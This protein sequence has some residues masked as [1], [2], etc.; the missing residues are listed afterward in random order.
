[1]E[2]GTKYLYLKADITKGAAWQPKTDVVLCLNGH[3]FTQTDNAAAIYVPYTRSFTLCDC[4][5]KGTVTSKGAGNIVHLEGGATH[6]YT[7]FTMYGGNLVGNSQSKNAAVVYVS[8][9]NS[10]GQTIFNLYGGTISGN[11]SY[12]DGA[13]VRNA[14]GTFNMYGGTITG[15]TVNITGSSNTRARGAGV[16]NSGTFTMTGGTITG[17]TASGSGN[18]GGGVYN[19]GATMKISGKVNITGNTG[20]NVYLAKS[21]SSYTPPITI[22]GALDKS[23]KIGV[24][25]EATPGSSYLTVATGAENG[26]YDNITSDSGYYATRYNSDVLLSSDPLHIHAD[27]D[28]MEH[29]WTEFNAGSVQANGYYYLNT[30]SSLKTISLSGTWAPNGTKGI[31][32]CL[33]GCTLGNRENQWTISLVNGAELSIDDCQG[34]GKIARGYNNSGTGS[35]GGGIMISGGSTLTLNGGTITGNNYYNGAGVWIAKGTFIMNG[36]E[37][38][39]NNATEGGG[40]Y[41]AQG[42]KFEMNGGKITDNTGGG[43][44]LAA[45]TSV[46]TV[47][48]KVTITGN[49]GGNVYLK[50]GSTITIGSV[51]NDNSRIGV[52]VEGDPPKTVATGANSASTPYTGIFFADQEDQGYKV[53]QNSTTLMLGKHT[54]DWKF[55]VNEAGDTVTATCGNA[56]GEVPCSVNGGNG[57]SITIVKPAHA[58]YNDGLSANATW[59]GSFDSAVSVTVSENDIVY[60]KGTEELEGAPTDAGTYTAKLTVGDKEIKVTYTIAR[61][62]LNAGKFVLA[63]DGDLTYNGTAKFVDV[64]GPNGVKFTWKC[65]DKNGSEV[66]PINAGDYT[67]KVTV[68]GNANY[69]DDTLTSDKWT[70]TILRAEQKNAELTMANWNFG[71]TASDPSVTGAQENPT[72]TYDYKAKGAADS[73]YTG[74]KPSAAGDY[75]VR[76]TIAE[77]GNYLEKVLTADFT[78]N[79]TPATLIGAPTPNDRTYNG[80]NQAL[81]IDKNVTVEHGEMMYSLNGTNYSYGVP[82]RTDAGTYTVWYMVKG[83]DGYG[84]TEPAFVTVTI[85]KATITVTPAAGQNKVYGQNDPTLNFTASAGQNGETASFNG[86]LGRDTGENVGSYAITQGTLALKDNGSFKASNYELVVETDSTFEITKKTLT[87]LDLSGLTVTKVY[88][89]GTGAGTLTGTIGFVGKV[90]NDDVS[91]LVETVGEYDDANVG[92][93]KTITLTLKLD[94]AQKYCYTLESGTIQFASAEITQRNVE[95]TGAAVANKTYDGNT[96]APVTSVTIPGLNGNLVMGTDFEI[97]S[98]TFSDKNAGDNKT[99]TIQVELI[100]GAATNYSLTS[101]TYMTTAKIEQRKVHIT[102]ITANSREYDGT[103]EANS[104]LTVGYTLHDKVDGDDVGVDITAVFADANVIE[105]NY[106][107]L[108]YTLTGADKD[109]YVVD[110]T[111]SNQTATAMIEQKELTITDVTIAPKTYDGTNTASITGVTFDGLVNGETLTVETDYTVV[112]AFAFNYVNVPGSNTVQATVTLKNSDT[113]KN[114]TF[115]N[116][117]FPTVKK[118]FFKSAAIGPANQPITAGSV[119]SVYGETD[120]KVVVSGVKE[121][122]VLTFASDNNNIIVDENG[123]LTFLKSGTATITVTAAATANYNATTIMVKVNV[124][125][126]DI[127]ISALDRTAYVGSAPDL[128]APTPGTDYEIDGLVDGDDLDNLT[129]AMHYEAENEDGSRT[130]IL[131]VDMT[132]GTYIIVIELVSGTDD[133]YAIMPCEAGTLTLDAIPAYT[134]KVNDTEH[135]TAASNRRS[136]ARGQ[137]VTITVTPDEGYVLAGLTVT[138]RSGKTIAVTDKGDGKYTFKMPGSRVTVSASFRRLSVFTDIDDAWY[139]D[140]ILWAEEMNIALDE[141]GSG[142]F[143]P[144]EDCTRA[145]IVTFLWRAA[146]CPEPAGTENPFTDVSESDPWY[147]AVL[148]AWET[149]VTKGYGVPTLFAP[150]A[151]STRAQTVLFLKRAAK[152]DD[153]ATGNSFTD[154][155]EGAYYEAGVNWAVS[156]GLTNGSGTASTFAPNRN[157]SRAEIIAFIHRLL[158]K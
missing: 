122:A 128:S 78:I 86:A 93:G 58:T 23:A 47:S 94:G 8:A 88:D 152:A 53:Y 80:L 61:A 126:K 120:R 131:P 73:T 132:P 7:T 149:G 77:T 83:T 13:G 31:H 12:D 107:K 9:P 37:I 42:S 69:A 34:G 32:L 57:G 113:A 123:Q 98:A 21:G 92:T 136:A 137:T 147:K 106:I 35:T 68:S 29:I 133:R 65:Y 125:K 145:G 104:C 141:D 14:G 39:N 119:N 158:T 64:D 102:G 111:K 109:N 72:V 19:N 101:D 2:A 62:T 67:V 121:D 138:D 70:F 114:Y 115:M 146:G 108:S 43:V 74:T 71:G 27:S 81:V 103:T 45:D 144:M 142:L 55:T 50:E 118:D 41:V 40:V 90:G 59:T 17:N 116:S 150:T 33:N 127:I 49:T 143:R 140:D 95:I 130:P 1:M 60:Y 38:R 36:G 99:V 75:T 25:T 76:A 4:K 6:N 89:S 56:T 117:K 54:H 26:Y 18:T 157:C 5:N 16:Y 100:G 96:D 105:R 22:V 153:V 10:G 84:D 51:L 134:V 139:T 44:W 129:F 154:V 148:W 24:S 110:M 63:V 11:T 97:V 20:G 82:T 91:I 155:P 15:N 28:G 48:G 151:T 52:S 135:G 112:G 30:S 124:D 46:F 79:P 156:E 87:N 85:S 66:E 3:T